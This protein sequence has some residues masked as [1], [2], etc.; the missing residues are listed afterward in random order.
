MDVLLFSCDL[1]NWILTLLVRTPYCKQGNSVQ[2][3]LVGLSYDRSASE[4]F[5]DSSEG[6]IAVIH[7]AQPVT[8]LCL[9]FISGLD[10][11]TWLTVTEK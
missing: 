10:F 2:W 3:W 8:H 6:L 5:C 9:A 1:E 11:L 7:L 4:F